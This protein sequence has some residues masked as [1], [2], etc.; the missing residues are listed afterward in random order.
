M[1][2]KDCI[3]VPIGW[4]GL[5]KIKTVQ[6]NLIGDVKVEHEFDDVLKSQSQSA[7]KRAGNQQVG[8]CMLK[9]LIVFSSCKQ[10]FGEQYFPLDWYKTAVLP[11]L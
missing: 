5:L 3:A 9:V 4:D 6:D 2:E 8:I 7:T 10:N 11:N 1:V